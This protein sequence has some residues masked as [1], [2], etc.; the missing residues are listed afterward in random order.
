[1]L[2]RTLF[3]SSVLLL[4]FGCAG[5]NFSY[6]DARQIKAGMT[7]DQVIAVMKGKPNVTEV[8]GSETHFVWAYGNLAGQAKQLRVRFDG[9]GRVIAAPVLP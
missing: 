3:L 8:H 5:T 4:A 9:G 1:M 2:L 6:S 7:T